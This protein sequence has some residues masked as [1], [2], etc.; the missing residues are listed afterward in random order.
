MKADEPGSA[1]KAEKYGMPIQHAPRIIDRHFGVVEDEAAL[2]GA[3]LLHQI[4]Q[5]R[6]LRAAEGRARQLA[7]P[8]L[9]TPAQPLAEA[10]P[11]AQDWR[12]KLGLS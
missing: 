5:S 12:A 10:L 1:P 2:A 8:P 9:V 6:V 4:K 3:Q 7:A 11:E